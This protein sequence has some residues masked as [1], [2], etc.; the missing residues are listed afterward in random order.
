M[1]LPE[2]I[3]KFK[4][5]ADLLGRLLSTNVVLLAVSAKPRIRIKPRRSLGPARRLSG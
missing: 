3:M 5:T 2:V 1:V 4:T